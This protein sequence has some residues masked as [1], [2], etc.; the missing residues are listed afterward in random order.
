[1]GAQ[2]LR[3]TV[4]TAVCAALATT[5]LVTGAVGGPGAVPAGASGA[6]VI[7]LLDCVWNGVPGRPI[8]YFGYVSANAVNKTIGI[9]AKN[10]FTPSSPYPADRG[11]P[12]VFIPGPHP[13]TFAVSFT[14][15]ALSWSLTG[16]DKVVRTVTAD[17]STPVCGSQPFVPDAQ[18]T[19]GP[20]VGTVTKQKYAADH[21]TLVK[22]SVKFSMAATSGCTG[23]GVPLKP[24]V[25]YYVLPWDNGNA[26]GATQAFG[27]YVFFVNSVFHV[28][29]PQLMFPPPVALGNST[30]WVMVSAVGHCDLGDG[31]ALTSATDWV[32]NTP[33][34]DVSVYC[35][36]TDATVA[37]EVTRAGTFPS[38]SDPGECETTAPGG[39]GGIKMR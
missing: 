27:P 16:P 2:Q 30:G 10:H 12:K 32:P 14:S 29:D 31:Y 11:Q 6:P 1:M 3:R 20:I 28:S 5:A 25:T 7:P 8:A 23:S 13:D 18:V 37:P 33:Q 36:V 39:G 21:V 34:T 4:G 24:T 15:A 35:Y 22:A 19:N 26:S 38:P 9:G 17:G